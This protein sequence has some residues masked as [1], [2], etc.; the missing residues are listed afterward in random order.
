MVRST[1]S[2]T[3]RAALLAATLL[4]SAP[5]AGAETFEMSAYT[6]MPGGT[7]VMSGDYDAAIAAARR[8]TRDTETQLVA[9]TNL[10]V[11]YTLKGAFSEALG[12]CERALSLAKRIDR[13]WPSRSYSETPAMVKALSNRGVLRALTGDSMGA[14]SDF[15]RAAEL[16]SDADAPGRNLEYL[17]TTP[18]Y[19]MA[20]AAANAD[21]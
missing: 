16:A 5:N 20:L 3:A 21:N 4:A 8:P 14:E 1:K 12:S 2:L 17:E 18:A 7:E 10:C 13:A 15:R 9:S 6:N 11:A 19:R